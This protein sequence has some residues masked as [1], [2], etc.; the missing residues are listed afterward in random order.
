M[1]ETPTISVSQ[2][3]DSGDWKLYATSYNMTAPAGPRLFRAPPHPDIRWAHTSEESATADAAKLQA[4]IDKEAK[5]RQP[6]KRQVRNAG[7]D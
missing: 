7:A 2:D 1:T 5:K 3:L 4:Y 6:T